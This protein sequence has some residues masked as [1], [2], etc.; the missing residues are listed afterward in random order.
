AQRATPRGHRPPRPPAA[1]EEVV[2]ADPGLPPT[3]QLA[4]AIRGY[5]T[6]PGACT[7]LIEQLAAAVERG[8]PAV[9]GV[10]LLHRFPPE[11]LL[12]DPPPRRW[13]LATLLEAA[14]DL[15][16]FAPLALTWYRFS[17]AVAAYP[18]GSQQSLLDF[19]R[20]GG[21][22]VQPLAVSAVWIAGLVMLVIVLT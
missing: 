3:P 22:G 12:P 21:D 11:V 13:Q 1:R 20:V 15:S 14:R 2:V 7:V 4:D 10:D 6:V 18:N 5:A 19:W 17:A 9:V 16:I 8:E